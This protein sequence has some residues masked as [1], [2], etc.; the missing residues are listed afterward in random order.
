[1]EKL[2]TFFSIFRLN[3]FLMAAASVAQAGTKQEGWVTASGNFGVNIT[4][5]ADDGVSNISIS[6]GRSTD[7]A[8]YFGFAVGGYHGHALRKVVELE[9]PFILQ[10]R[11]VSGE[12][13]K[14]PLI[15]YMAGDGAWTQP[16]ERGLTGSRATAF[17]DD[18]SRDGRLTLQ[19]GNGVE[20][21][22]WT[23]KGR[24][25]VRELMRNDCH[26]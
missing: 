25:K 22:S 9:Q 3:L 14:F 23:L 17:L 12:N 26:L 10:V 19:T 7:S 4:G 18:F 20:L 13:E 11:S 8:I 15:A 6:C 2:H 24:S 16:R 1:M 21:A 5:F